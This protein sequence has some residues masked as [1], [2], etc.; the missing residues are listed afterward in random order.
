MTQ[1]SKLPW[2]FESC[3]D[4]TLYIEDDDSS[5]VCDMWPSDRTNANAALIVEAVNSHA[6]LV[7]RVAKLESLVD[8]WLDDTTHYHGKGLVPKYFDQVI[9]ASTALLAKP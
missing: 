6:A 9:A 5:P 2:S 7:E 3:A 1:V 8:A 4:D